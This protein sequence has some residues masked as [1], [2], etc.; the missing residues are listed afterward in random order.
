MLYEK[1]IDQEDNGALQIK[2]ID[3]IHQ[4]SWNEVPNDVQCMVS[5][6][7]VDLCATLIGGRWTELSAI[8]R[9]VAVNIFGGQEA[10]LLL[11]GRRASAPGAA[12]ANGM[13]IDSMDMHDGFRPAKGHAGV[14]IFPA[15]LAMGEVRG[16][17]GEEF[18]AALVVGYEVALRAA[19]ALHT[20][21]CDY[22]T[23]GA[24]GALGAAALTSRALKLDRNQ[25]NHALGIAEYHG[26]R[27]QMMRCID[28]PTMLKDGS[29]WGGMTG[30]VAGRLAAKGFTGAP[31]VTVESEEIKLVWKDL[32]QRWLMRELYFKP[33]AVCR[34]A[35]PAVEGARRLATEHQ[36]ALDQIEHIHVDTFEVA[37]H[38]TMKHPSN[39]EQAQYSLPYPVAAILVDGRL[40]PEQV[41]AP[42][43]FDER[44]LRLADSVT[45]AVDE[46][47]EAQYPEQALARVKIY[48]SD[49]LELE[50]DICTAPGDP[51]NPLSDD[52][53]IDKFDRLA[54]AYLSPARLKA[55]R[56]ACWDLASLPAIED[57]VAL[58]APMPEKYKLKG[59]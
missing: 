59:E 58:L 31:A 56:I 29:G 18:A 13:T 37:A 23:S 33:Y 39:T 34:W 10:T 2:V 28:H 42:R 35:Q 12:L 19:V 52:A 17:S 55:L 47:L 4:L 44:I 50:S 5:R 14:N 25:T 21:S 49:G 26:P 41:T 27:S 24:W 36:L 54:E 11:D 16:W 30:L 15:A 6:C 9:D 22:H 48:T 8:V 40:D 45:V 20:T 57:F 3:F 32:G 46:D 51:S 7:M 1:T 43:I 38:L 53:L